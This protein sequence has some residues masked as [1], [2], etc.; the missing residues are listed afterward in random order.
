MPAIPELRWLRQDS[1]FEDSLGYRPC[2]KNF[3]DQFEGLGSAA[4]GQLWNL[5]KMTQ[6]WVELESVS[7]W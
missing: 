5:R 1:K 7:S 4:I 6:S 2:L 3:Q